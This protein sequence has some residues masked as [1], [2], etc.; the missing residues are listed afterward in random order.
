VFIALSLPVAA[1]GL[2]FSG[3][4]EKFRQWVLEQKQ[5]L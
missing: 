2:D 5:R 3:D 1:Q 4:K